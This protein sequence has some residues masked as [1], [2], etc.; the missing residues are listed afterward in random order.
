MTAARDCFANQGFAGASTPQIVKEADVTR[1][2]L[3]HHFKDKTD[4]FRAVVIA[5]STE[6]AAEI[7]KAAGGDGDSFADGA[8]A[9]FDAMARPGRARIL[10]QDGPA[11]LGTEVMATID[12]ETGGATLCN[13]IITAQ[14]DLP[15]AV[16]LRLAELLSA[17]F[18][19][20]ALSVAEGAPKEDWLIAITLLGQAALKAG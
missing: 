8:A 5:E 10:L 17:A 6:V 20:A 7:R 13:A 2:A 1:G 19:R 9:Y 16:A 11:A 18:D 3:Y 12:A 15:D 14:P 4:L